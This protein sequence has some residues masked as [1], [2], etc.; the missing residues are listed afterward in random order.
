MSFT[1]PVGKILEKALNDFSSSLDKFDPNFDLHQDADAWV[2]KQIFFE[3]ISDAA[4]ALNDP[5]FNTHV[6][7]KMEDNQ[8]LDIVGLCNDAMR[9]MVWEY[10]LDNYVCPDHVQPE[11]DETFTTGVLKKE[12]MDFVAT[13][14][15]GLTPV[16]VNTLATARLQTATLFTNMRE[17]AKCMDHEDFIEAIDPRLLNGEHETL[18]S[19]CNDAM[20]SVMIRYICDHYSDKG[21][22]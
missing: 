2:N 1:E 7:T 21:E 22:Q 13:H 19:L 17:I 20:R 12:V 5:S 8:Y 15:T 3:R 9:Q 10:I 18:L 11:E 14:G 16:E 4:E 6:E